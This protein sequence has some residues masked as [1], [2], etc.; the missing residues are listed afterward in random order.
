MA[1]LPV[2][3]RQERQTPDYCATGCTGSRAARASRPQT[4]VAL[5][6]LC[7]QRVRIDKSSPVGHRERD[8]QRE[9]Q[10]EGGGSQIEGAHYK[11]PR[12]T[13]TTAREA[14]TRLAHRTTVAARFGAN[15]EQLQSLQW[16]IKNCCSDRQQQQLSGVRKVQ[17][18]KSWPLLVCCTAAQSERHDQTY[19]SGRAILSGRPFGVRYGREDGAHA[20]RRLRVQRGSTAGVVLAGD[21]LLREN[22][23]EAP[24]VCVARA[25]A[26]GARP[27]P[28]QSRVPL[29]ARATHQT[30]SNRSGV[31]RLGE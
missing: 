8:A 9:H 17:R 4:P 28:A 6:A 26:S 16:V 25:H 1:P 31:D 18:P 2:A 11:P 22:G 10:H 7:T 19:R 29:Q 24:N 13:Q 20:S 14:R 5:F 30:I 12:A 23:C 27:P 21:V 3:G 15:G